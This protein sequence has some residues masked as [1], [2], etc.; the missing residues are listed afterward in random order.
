MGVGHRHQ[1]VEIEVG[2]AGPQAGHESSGEI[3]LLDLRRPGIYSNAPVG[4]K[5]RHYNKR[6]ISVD[7]VSLA[8]INVPVRR[9]GGVA[10][11][12]AVDHHGLAIRPA[13]VQPVDQPARGHTGRLGLRSAA[14]RGKKVQFAA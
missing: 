9:D 5:G 12:P 4:T 10:G 2:P 7:L 1:A 14:A 3:G 13:V 11:E 6:V 8:K